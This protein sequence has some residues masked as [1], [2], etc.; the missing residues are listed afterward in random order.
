M[1]SGN[2][3]TEAADRLALRSLASRYASAVDDGDA[4]ALAACFAPGGRLVVY[5]PGADSPL[6]TWERPDGFQ[7]LVEVLRTTYARTFHLIGS[8]WCDVEDDAAA[9]ETYCLACHL[10]RTPEGEFEEV[11]VI[12]YKDEYL[13]TREG[14]RFKQRSAYRQWTTVLEARRTDR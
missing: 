7:R 3:E 2:P 13:R 12:R 1:A 4:A 5:E 10:R 9:G 14:W 11:A 8:H 6:R